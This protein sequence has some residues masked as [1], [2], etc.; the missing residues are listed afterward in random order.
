[1][2]KRFFASWDHGGWFRINS[3][4]YIDM[5][6][7][8]YVKPEE[9]IHEV[10]VKRLEDYRAFIEVPDECD[11]GEKFCKWVTLSLI[12]MYEQW[13]IEGGRTPW[14]LEHKTEK[15]EFFCSLL[16]PYPLNESGLLHLDI[17]DGKIVTMLG[18]KILEELPKNINCEWELENYAYKFIEN[19]ISGKAI[20]CCICGELHP[21]ENM[22][23][24]SRRKEKER[25]IYEKPFY[26]YWY[27]RWI[28]SPKAPHKNMIAQYIYKDIE[29]YI[30]PMCLEEQQTEWWKAA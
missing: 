27:N 9:V 12:P 28:V 14:E 4:L 16:F 5:P 17:R 23:V 26:S 18:S 13:K 8:C 22:K 3:E 19:K 6:D 21:P 11:T 20:K 1:M 24:Y 15:E 10:V 30:C 7:A 25:Q 29:E 2:S